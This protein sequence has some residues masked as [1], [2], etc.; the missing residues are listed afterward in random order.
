MQHDVTL[1]AKINTKKEIGNNN[2]TTNIYKL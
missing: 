2:T 1:C